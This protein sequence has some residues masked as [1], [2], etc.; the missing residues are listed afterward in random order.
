MSVNRTEGGLSAPTRHNIEWKEDLFY[1]T[2]SLNNE[3]SRVFEACH[4][5][6]RCVSLCEA[7]PTLFDLIDESENFDL[8]SVD[9]KDFIKVVDECY[10]CDLCYQTKCPYVPPHEWA[11]DFPHLMLRAK[12]EKFKTQNNNTKKMMRLRN[13]IL[14][15]T[16][17]VF[18]KGSY[19]II[20]NLINYLLTNRIVRIILEKILK[21]HR[22]ADLPLMNSNNIKKRFEKIKSYKIN[23][24]KTQKTNGKVK[25]FS[26]CYCTSSHPELAED[27][28]KVFLHNNIQT[29]IFIMKIAV[30]CQNLNLET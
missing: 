15:S 4:G 22:D 24:T 16:D 6:R 2:T 26:T 11:I 7:F 30:V 28:I 10:M 21:I 14:S 13:Y 29:E 1:D 9:T 20:S 25:L 27:L 19:P 12:A 17:I 23:I 3:L 8:E 5:C 18:K